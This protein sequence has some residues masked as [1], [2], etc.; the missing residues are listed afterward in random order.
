M[1]EHI[2]VRVYIHR[3]RGERER[4]SLKDSNKVYREVLEENG[5]GISNDI[6]S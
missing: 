1:Y 4:E 2:N 5:K 6:I 3:E